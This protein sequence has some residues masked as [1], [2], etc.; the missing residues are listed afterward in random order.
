MF[1]TFLIERLVIA[2]KFEKKNTT[3][4][5]VTSFLVPFHNRY[6]QHEIPEKI[7]KS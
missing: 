5:E 2:A 3:E 7:Y 4:I 6:E 1:P